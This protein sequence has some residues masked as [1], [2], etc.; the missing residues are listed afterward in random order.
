M[1][2]TSILKIA[3]VLIFVFTLQ[4]VSNAQTF[5]GFIYDDVPA[6]LK[7]EPSPTPNEYM[8]TISVIGN[9]ANAWV[10]FA[11]FDYNY[12]QSRQR[13]FGNDGGDTG[14]YLYDV[15]EDSG[16]KKGTILSGYTWS[17][18]DNYETRKMVFFLN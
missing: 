8:L 15:S 13:F 17:P 18:E 2:F 1:N 7:I 14:M 5:K 4:S 12:D 10:F 3:F 16:L 6:T 11:E 9:E